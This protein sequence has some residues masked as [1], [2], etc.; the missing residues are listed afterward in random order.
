MDTLPLMSWFVR[1]S[2]SSS[3]VLSIYKVK[4]ESNNAATICY[5]PLESAGTLGLWPSAP[6]INDAL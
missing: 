1:H 5:L 6:V 3:R 4:Y 2:K